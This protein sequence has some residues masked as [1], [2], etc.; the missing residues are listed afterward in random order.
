MDQTRR[1]REGS[2]WIPKLCKI[3]LT[4]QVILL[5]GLW[6]KLLVWSS[7]WNGARALLCGR[8]RT[9]RV[10]PTNDV[11]Q[12]LTTLNL[13]CI[14][15]GHTK[16]SRFFL[17]PSRKSLLKATRHSV[18]FVLNGQNSEMPLV[19]AGLH[20]PQHDERNVKLQR[21]RGWEHQTTRSNQ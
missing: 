14:C 1:R 19:E 5:H 7:T 3:L 2:T 15:L 17:P 10:P 6:Q 4:R 8:T 13:P 16:F 21:F 12:D 18:W 20:L 11:S 9:T